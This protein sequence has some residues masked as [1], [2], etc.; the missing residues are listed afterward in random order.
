MDISAVVIVVSLISLA[1]YL[2]MRPD[3]RQGKS[4]K[5]PPGPYPLPVVGNIF[6]LGDKPNRSVTKLAK[7]Y[8]PVMSLRL[9]SILNVVISSPEMAKEVLQKYDHVF[10]SRFVASSW[11]AHDHHN[12]SVPFLP[13]GNRWRKMRK[14]F[15]DV[16]LSHPRLDGGRAIRQTMIKNLYE[17]LLESSKTGKVVNIGAAATITSVNLTSVSLFSGQV[18]HFDEDESTEFKETFEGLTIAA[19]RPNLSDFFPIIK[20][21]D[22]QGC[23]RQM[24]FYLG[25]LLEM[26]DKI[27][28]ERLKEMRTSPASA[29]KNDMLDTLLDFCRD[30]ENDMSLNDIKHVLVDLFVGASDTASRTIEW[31]ITELLLHPDILAKAKEELKNVIGENKLVQESDI[32]NLPYMEAV[33]KEVFRVHPVGP[34]LI[35]RRLEEDTEL[36]G[37]FIPKGTQIFVNVWSI[38]RDE[39]VWPN[40]E[41]F[42][43]ERFLNNNID[44]K[45]QDFVLLPF[46][47]GRRMCPGVPLA[48]RMLYTMIGTFIHSFDWKFEPGV[49]P[50]KVDMNEAFGIV[51]HKAVP[52]K[53]IPIKA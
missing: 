1:Y 43:P 16:M 38:H 6:Q 15:R 34:F 24:A 41:S 30:K 51:L 44:Y 9:G 7:K 46:G 33:I 35:P 5:L 8:G 53:A 49:T 23:K 11:T 45:G 40:P 17:Y 37:Y 26:F 20:P 52:L 13:V 10:S 2:L 36:S 27:V 14:L 12:V 29:R 47:S 19:G 4:A 31:A 48:H 21:F 22:I 28:N 39:K 32:P 25:K 42:E 3:L 18:F 50:E